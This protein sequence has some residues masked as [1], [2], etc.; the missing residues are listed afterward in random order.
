[1]ESTSKSNKRIAAFTLSNIMCSEPY[2]LQKALENIDLINLL[3]EMIHREPEEIVKECIICFTNSTFRGTHEQICF[4]IQNGTFNIFL[5]YL[6]KSNPDFDIVDEILQAIMNILNMASVNL[7]NGR[8]L[9]KEKLEQ[10]GFIS[11]LDHMQMFNNPKTQK[12]CLAIVDKYFDDSSVFQLN[13][14]N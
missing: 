13:Q 4:L 7:V 1:M 10:L 5:E 11:I 2:Q 8:N 14:M 3:I 12:T 9:F 6:T